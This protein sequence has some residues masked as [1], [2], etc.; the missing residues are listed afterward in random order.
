M[1]KATVPLVAFLLFLFFSNNVFSQTN[2]LLAV[3]Q[4]IAAAVEKYHDDYPREKAYVQTDRNIY[5]AGETIWM[6]AW[7]T[8]EGKPSPYSRIFYTDLINDKGIV[9][10]K[11]MYRLDSM[12]STACDITLPQNI[13]AGNYRLRG[14]SLWMMNFINDAFTANIF[15]TDKKIQSSPATNNNSY[16]M[17]F[18][19]EGGYL[20]E[21]VESVVSCKVT[22]K[23]GTGQNNLAVTIKNNKGNIVAGFTTEHDGMSSFVFTPQAGE[24]YTASLQNNVPF[25]LPAAEKE[26]V[27]L[28]VSN[29]SKS[30]VSVIVKKNTSAP[31]KYN[32]LLIVAQMHSTVVFMGA[33]NF[34][35]G[36]TAAAIN[37]KDLPPGIMQVTLFDE[38][39]M[40][41]AERIVFINNIA[42]TPVEVNGLGTNATKPDS[43]VIKLPAGIKPNLSACVVQDNPAGSP[44][45]EILLSSQFLT[46]DIN[47]E[48]YN[49]NY[50]FSANDSAVNRHLDLLM[51][52]QGWRRYKWK[53]LLNNSL[54][55]LKYVTE[56]AI[57]VKGNV[58]IPGTKERI[59]NGKVN[60]FIKGADSTSLFSVA[61]LTDKGEF[62]FDNLNIRKDA[63]IYYQATNSKK[64]NA[65]TDVT[66]YPAYI[67]SLKKTNDAAIAKPY[68]AVTGNEL[69]AYFNQLF[70][71][72]SVY[73]SMQGVTVTATKKSPVDSLNSLYATG[74]FANNGRQINPD[75][76]YFNIWQLMRT[77]PGFSIEGNANSPTVTVKRAAGLNVFG[78]ASALSD[79]GGESSSDMSGYVENGIAYYLNEVPV[80]K[81]VIDGISMNDV[82]YI[83]TFIGAETAIIGPFDGVISVYTK[84]GTATGNSI[85]DK[86]FA[87]LKILGYATPKE[88]YVPAVQGKNMA[89]TNPTLLWK[90]YLYFSKNGEAKLYINKEKLKSPST[91]LIQGIDAAGRIY[92]FR[93]NL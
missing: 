26:G 34:E 66:I 76:Y 3:Q 23:A 20:V 61:N 6:K 39:G 74:Q 15:V 86:S 84:M 70:T 92:Y 87:R 37:K 42:A 35:E 46:S 1:L 25:A 38:T 80:S 54:P 44:A 56:Q 5:A 41:L 29:T 64:E 48:V 45:A 68:S 63:I 73:K 72:D 67:D 82:A 21:G 31:A 19:P 18:F 47:G 30:R 75:G 79:A 81:D 53:E 2:D 88:F 10:E 43:I 8:Y 4:R 28:K 62:I 83:K 36:A 90:P 78:D 16:S 93:K 40:P 27:V 49:P 9:I 58:T 59:T 69:S 89:V 71:A 65:I 77:I 12:S 85:I 13:A 55:S 57:A 17:A 50:Y 11:K 22:D 24:T 33:V 7:L 91:L 52:T 32:K 51:L 14:Y 60:M